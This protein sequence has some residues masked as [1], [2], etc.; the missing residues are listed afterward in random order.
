MKSKTSSDSILI[1]IFIGAILLLAFCALG[2]L[3]NAYVK[4]VF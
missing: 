4:G 1:G 2:E 3:L